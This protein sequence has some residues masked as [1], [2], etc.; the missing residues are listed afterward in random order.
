MPKKLLF[1]IRLKALIL[2]IFNEKFV[3]QNLHF[4]VTEKSESKPVFYFYQ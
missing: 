2:N 1:L 4:F 3:F